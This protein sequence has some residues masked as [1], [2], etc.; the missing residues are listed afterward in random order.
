[1]TLAGALAA[2]RGWAFVAGLSGHSAADAAAEVAARR[3]VGGWA[4]VEEVAL[5][6]LARGDDA[7]VRAVIAAAPT[8]VPAGEALARLR[9]PE[10]AL[11]AGWSPGSAVD[12][13]LAPD[14]AWALV[15]R[16]RLVEARAAVSR[17][18]TPT[19]AFHRA[20][21]ADLSLDPAGAARA[22]AEAAAP[23][24]TPV[25][26]GTVWTG[27]GRNTNFEDSIV[28][29]V[30]APVSRVAVSGRVTPCEGPP[31]LSVRVG[32]REPVAL[33]LGDAPAHADL[34]LAPGAYRLTV[35][36]EDDRAT[37]ACDRNLDAVAI[38]F[39]PARRT[40]P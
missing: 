37:A 40:D 24:G 4:T 26:P 9:G 34:A 30:R 12:P 36:W 14:L 33:T 27:N 29:A 17:V 1:V 7:G 38:A 11:D 31:V 25:A 5:A 28:I 6:E 22:L 3:A 35:R 20:A 21:I 23:P 32:S 10:V 15:A 19:T 13:A 39:E 2:A 18:D 8:R 16:G